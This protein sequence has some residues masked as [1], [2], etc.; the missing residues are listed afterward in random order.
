M[1]IKIDSFSDLK[2]TDRGPSAKIKAGNDTYYVNEDPTNLVGKTVEMEVTEKISAK[3][4]KYKIAK[5]IKVLEAAASSGNGHG[6]SWDDYRQMAEAAHELAMKLEADV[7]A[8]NGQ[9]GVPIV[10]VDRSHARAAILNTV[11]IAF[12]NGKIANP[13]IDDDMPF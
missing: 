4:N 5:I 10:T 9:E 11:M 3:G 8:D 7:F 1:Q 2:T 6:I 12:S 13:L